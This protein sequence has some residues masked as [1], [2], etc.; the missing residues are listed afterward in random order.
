MSTQGDPAE[1]GQSPNQDPQVPG[2]YREPQASHARVKKHVRFT[3]IWL[4]PILVLAVVGYVVYDMVV[5]RGTTIELTFRTAD[6]LVP[7]ETQVKHKN[8]RIGTVEDVRLSDDLSHVTAKVRIERHT[9]SILTDHARFWVVRPRF[10]KGLV[11]GLQSGLDTLVSGAYIAIDPGVPGG[12]P[13]KSFTGME[14]PPGVRSDEPGKVIILRAKELGSLSPGSSLYFRDIAVGEVLKYEFNGISDPIALRVFVRAPYDKFVVPKSRFYNISGLNVNVGASGLHV[15]L[16]SIQAILAGGIAF[17]TP[18]GTNAAPAADGATFQLWESKAASDDAQFVDSIHCVTYFDS[19]VQGLA[20]GAKVNL[21][22]AMVGLV[23]DVRT[24]PDSK[25]PG[26]WLA[27][28]A[29]DIQPQRMAV[30]SG[31]LLDKVDTSGAMTVEMLRSHPPKIFL[32]SASFI[33]GEKVLDLDYSGG[34]SKKPNS[35]GQEGDAIVLDGQNGGLD[36]VTVAMG[37]IASKIEQIPF[38]DIGKNLDATLVSVRDTV[39]NGDLKNAIAE[40]NTTM[41]DVH[42]LVKNTDSG[43]TPALAKLPGMADQLNQAIENANHAFGNA[44]YGAD[45]DFQRNASRMMKQ[46]DDAM[47]SIR[48]LADFLDKHPESLIRGRTNQPS[49]DK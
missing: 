5:R 38:D 11:S 20:A 6:G 45:S 21:L 23:R 43:L 41:Q 1:Q 26:N 46:V 42:K 44:G 14:E 16:T 15:E 49:G 30:G 32:D 28:V 35:V 13:E 36:N 22:G 25:K 39:G 40:L 17:E 7:G 2:G 31:P 12:K 8:V 33:T 37:R 4:V 10:Q 3:P 24:V 9:D 34:S 47:R 48:L 29:F 27:R 19:S 18:E